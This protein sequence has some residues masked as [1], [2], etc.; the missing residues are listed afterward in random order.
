METQTFKFT[1]DGIDFTFLDI[2]GSKT[3]PYVWNEMENDFYGLNSVELT[4]DDTVIDVGANVG[5]FSIYVK[6][7]F[8]CKVIAFEPIA[9]NFENLK[10][11][12]L[13]NGFSE[14]DFELHQSAITDIE[15]GEISIGTPISNS[16]GSSVFERGDFNS[17]CR[18]E[19]IDKYINNKCAYLKMDCE[20]G[21][22]SIIP[23]ILSLINNFKYIGIEYHSYNASQDAIGLNNQ[24]SNI[25]KGRIFSNIADPQASWNLGR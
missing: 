1:K 16:G 9:Q 21:E 10:K 20:G 22:Y 17:L 8:G 6:K 19:K 2:D 18:T 25:F 3:V 11:N 13:L 14:S 5:L 7:K 24:I 12:I 15:G 23:Y 4:E